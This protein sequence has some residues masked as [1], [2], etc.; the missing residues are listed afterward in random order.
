MARP[1]RHGHVDLFDDPSWDS[2]E[3]REEA[4]AYVRLVSGFSPT[5]EWSILVLSV[6]LWFVGIA[7]VGLLFSAVMNLFTFSFGNFS[8]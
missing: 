3:S 1:Q 7:A 6:A 2:P 8:I 5:V 4:A